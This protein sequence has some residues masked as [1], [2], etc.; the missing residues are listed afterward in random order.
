MR[1]LSAILLLLPIALFLAAMQATLAGRIQLLGGQPNFLL[2]ALVLLTMAGGRRAALLPALV[3]A[4]LVD[5][6]AGLPLGASVAP[7]LA[8]IYLA[9]LGERALFG[10]RL[11]WPMFITLVATVVADAILMFELSLL[12]RDF[13]WLD[14]FLR[15]T[16][17]GAALNAALIFVLYLPIDYWR[18]SRSPL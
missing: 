9:G 11:G 1:H 12:G 10:A 15:I 17:P 14:A 16:L 6:L 7:M 2:I 5:S 13:S 4:P 8:V 18:A 3:L